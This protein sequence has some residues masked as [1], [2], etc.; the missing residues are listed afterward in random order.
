[1]GTVSRPRVFLPPTVGSDTYTSF[2]TKCF[3]C[4]RIAC[5]AVA[6][7]KTI[8]ASAAEKLRDFFGCPVEKP[9]KAMTATVTICVTGGF[10]NTPATK[11][12]KSVRCRDG[13]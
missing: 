12:V 3:T 7:F 4:G 9:P 6:L 11:G 10:F 13:R 2:V 8:I 1:M 5:Y